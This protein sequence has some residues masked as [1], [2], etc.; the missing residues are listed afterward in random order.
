MAKQSKQTDT[1]DVPCAQCE[2]E[3]GRKTRGS[4]GICDR[5]MEEMMKQIEADRAAFEAARK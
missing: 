1:N 3:A 2:E 5:H 4:H